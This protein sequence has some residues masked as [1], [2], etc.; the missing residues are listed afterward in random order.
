MSAS[1]WS[2]YLLR[3][4]DGSI[5]TGI[6]IDVERRLT[7]HESGKRGARY[8]RGRGPLEL[9]FNR[10][11]GD[12]SIA[13]KLEYRLRRLPRADKRNPQRLDAYVDSQ[14][15]ELCGEDRGTKQ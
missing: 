12:R 2:V 4:G 13:S 14:L 1:E 9:I 15:Q 6:S 8:L 10:P 3:C 7:E 11:V 5:Y